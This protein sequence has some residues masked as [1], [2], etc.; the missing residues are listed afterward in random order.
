MLR[1]VTSW[2]TFSL[3]PSLLL[4]A[5]LTQAF[6]QLPQ[7][8]LNAVFP[9]GGQAGTTFDVS[10]TSGTDL[11]EVQ[12]LVFNH[13]GISA[14][15]KPAT[16]NQFSVSIA[17]DVPPGLY[18]VRCLGLWGISNPRYFAVGVRPER[19]ETEP[20]NTREQATPLEVN[21]T[22]NGKMNGGTDIDFYK[23]SL[24][25]GQRLIGEFL[26][27]R[28]DSRIDGAVEVYDTSGRRLAF[29]RNNVQRDPLLD[30]TPPAD[31]D[32][33]LRVF[34][35]VYAGGEE[36]AYRFT[37]HTG[38]YVDFI[39]PPAGV[40]GSTASYTLY[41]RNLPGG[42]PAGFAVGG[43]PLEKVTVD[44]ALP[45]DPARLE[46]KVPLDSP[47]AGIDAVTFTWNSPVGPSN[48]VLLGFAA[49]PVTL[50]REPN[51]AA[52]EAQSLSIPAEL[53]GQ[54]QAKADVD[55]FQF[56][57]KAQQVLWIEVL[58][59]RLG[60][61]ADPYLTLDQVVIND[62]GEE[63]LKRLAA[64]DD[65]AANLLPNVF[66]TNHDDPVYKFVV[67]ADGVYR[68]AVRDRYG[69]S[70][71]DPSLLYR[72]IIREE[73]PDF[74]LIVLPSMPTPPNQRQ[75]QIWAVGLRRGDQLAVPVLALRRDG[76]A[77][78]ITV[79]VEGLPPG[80]SCRDISI[81][82]SPSV[83]T[84]VFAAAEDAPPWAGT[85]QVVGTARIDQPKLVA[86]AVAA[87]AAQ[88]TAQEAL[89]A[90]EKALQKPNE[91]VQ[92]ATSA[93][94]VAKTELAAKPDDEALKKKVADAEAQLAEAQKAQQAAAQA[95]TAADQKL[96][97]ANA[98]LQQA[99]ETR[100][101]GAQDVVR[102][103]RIGTVVWNGQ[104]NV[105]GEVRLSQGLELSVVEEAAPV[106][107]V[108]EV[109]RVVAHHNRQILI[110]VKM[111][112]R[113]G[114]DANVNINFVGQPQNLQ[115][116]NKPINKDKAEEVFRVFVPP[117]V[118]V[119]TYVMSLV[120]QA[121]VSYRRNPAK[122]D[123]AKAEFDSATAAANAAV[124]AQKTA[125]AN[126]DAAVKKLMESQAALKTATETK[127]AA[128]KALRDAQAAEKAA[129]EALKNAGEDADAKAA[130]EKKLQ[131]AQAAVKAA[132]DSAAQA[133]KARAD[134]EAAAKSAEDAKVAAENELKA[135]EDK[136]K[137]TMAEK[138]A[139]EK[140]FKDA[141]NATKPQ[142]INVFPT[143]T[144]IVL[145]VKP[146]PCTLTANVANGGNIKAGD[147]LE[148]KVD[149][150]RQNGF[151]GPVTLTLPLP[152]G[153]A[154]VKAEPVVIPADQTTGVLVLEAAADAAEA[155]LANM[156]VRVL[157]EFEGEEAAVDQP[158][159][160][161]IVK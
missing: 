40:A 22:V 142:N 31:G 117:N 58:G 70:R 138:A 11:E 134:A 131:E 62:K 109:H 116:E 113:P 99:L 102:L 158:I 108:T 145:T 118:P 150:K 37:L 114:F 55:L 67:P 21:V 91:D 127:A 46:A 95:R 125:A 89:A 82:A 34:D 107:L 16:N 96:Q 161:K 137:A 124:E 160:L 2:P 28:I 100:R 155:A 39:F 43:K 77:G 71:G 112:K 101:A 17:S 153:V 92:K 52:A 85:V 51:N 83:G 144:P 133:E 54:F 49:L 156:V 60:S 151:A 110:P 121:Q 18:E 93:L 6:A 84:L 65:D 50:E 139:A 146:A 128:E 24:K 36:Y 152:P 122:Q 42:Q 27:K 26:G 45:N 154:G 73:S 119:G 14:A 86:A 15:A 136:V 5:G 79:R 157:A 59:H 74:R 1:R 88:K 12:R 90:A 53:A 126:R 123:R 149:I 44:V 33:F 140:R 32:Y 75:A 141:E 120:G 106:Q 68:L 135:A 81:G 64:A 76:F 132:E 41:G 105:P 8:R 104:P 23:V 130:A 63:T 19:M 115:V 38:P 3:L 4:V 61:G 29:A 25:A 20:N 143:T 7:T 147:K 35:F 10:I 47:S 78:D 87:Q 9:P 13:P 129:A 97:E 72:L 111:I 66:D 30:F 98:A 159:T 94:E 56:E 80:V 103:A 57:A 148:V 69:A 48:P